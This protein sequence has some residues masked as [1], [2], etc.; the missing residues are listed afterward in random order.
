MH[1][2]R[3]LL[4]TTKWRSKLQTSHKYQHLHVQH[5]SSHS[6]MTTGETWQLKLNTTEASSSS[7]SEF[8]SSDTSN[9]ASESELDNEHAWP[10]CAHLHNTK[11]TFSEKNT[12][13][14]RLFIC[15]FI[16]NQLL[17]EYWSISSSIVLT[18]GINS[19]RIEIPEELVLTRK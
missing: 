19:G 8:S 1:L 11:L 15:S 2:T 14:F 9:S 4:L 17:I 3:W 6:Q 7:S 13:S 5:Q 16:H 10:A 12:Y 18:P